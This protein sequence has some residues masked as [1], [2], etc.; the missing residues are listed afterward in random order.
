VKKRIVVIF[1]PFRPSPH[2]PR[3]RDRCLHSGESE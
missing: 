1:P 3:R 2:V